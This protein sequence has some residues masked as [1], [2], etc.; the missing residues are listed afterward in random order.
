MAAKAYSRDSHGSEVSYL[1]DLPADIR[2][3]AEDVLPPIP[4][5]GVAAVRVAALQLREAREQLHIGVAKREEGVD[6]APVEGVNASVDSSTFSSDIVRRVS[7]DPTWGATRSS[8]REPS[9]GN[10]GLSRP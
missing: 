9:K 5:T 2:P 6:V 7:A 4:H 1:L 8:L 3:Y 10:G